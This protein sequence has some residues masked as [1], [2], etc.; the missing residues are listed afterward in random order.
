MSYRTTVSLD[1][2]M[3]FAACDETCT[4]RDHIVIDI[5]ATWF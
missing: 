4:D 2:C 3:F 1:P 5:Q